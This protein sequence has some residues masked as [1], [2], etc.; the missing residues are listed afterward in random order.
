MVLKVFNM[1]WKIKNIYWKPLFYIFN[2][3]FIKKLKADHK[4]G[5]KY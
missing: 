4:N 2:K 5:L 3:N 1:N